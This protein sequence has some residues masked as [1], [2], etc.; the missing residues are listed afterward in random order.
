MPYGSN[1]VE[2]PEMSYT[3]ERMTHDATSI[4]FLAC[5]FVRLQFI[6]FTMVNVD[7]KQE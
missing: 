1:I 3:F 6:N 7:R 5:Y 4:D 2:S